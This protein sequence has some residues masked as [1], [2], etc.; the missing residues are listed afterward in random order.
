MNNT[1]NILINSKEKINSKKKETI[2]SKKEIILSEKRT[3][4]SKKGYSIKK[5][6]FDSKLIDKIKSELTV[7]PF[8]LSD[9]DDNTVPFPIY[10]ESENYLYSF[11]FT[12]PFSGI[13]EKSSLTFAIFFNRTKSPLG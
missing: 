7:K 13:S 6:D 5:L 11:P 12:Y 2:N 3:I 4:L 9:Y 10:R 1:K 8:I